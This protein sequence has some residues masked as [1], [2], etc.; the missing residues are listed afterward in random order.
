MDKTRGSRPEYLLR[1]FH[2]KVATWDEP[3]HI[4]ELL[5]IALWCGL[6]VD[7]CRYNELVMKTIL[8][9]TLIAL[10]PL[11]VSAESTG[12]RNDENW[13]RAASCNGSNPQT[14][15]MLAGHK[16][17]TPACITGKNAIE[18][19]LDFDANEDQ[20]AILPF[21]LP[22]QFAG[23]INVTIRWQPVSAIGSVG[24]CVE[25]IPAADLKRE[26]GASVTQTGRNCASEEAKT[27]A[28]HLHRELVIQV[29]VK[30]PPANNER[31]HIRLSR[32]ANS[33]VVL[34]DMPGDARLIGV[35]IETL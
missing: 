23:N 29:V 31:F 16:S 20:S 1:W 13:F 4:L 25:V 34:D 8:L 24:W 26:G 28:H 14:E 2:G 35:A 7:F 12:G 5:V 6:S 3:C 10:I 17:P 15:W 32:D 33:S 9:A 22:P 18:G 30:V 11:L 19:V 21:T 27:S